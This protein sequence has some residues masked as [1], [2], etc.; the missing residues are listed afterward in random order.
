MMDFGE[1][2]DALKA[3]LCVT[4]KGWNG[5]DMYLYLVD[6]SHFL[7]SRAPLNKLLPEGTKVDY[8][9]HIDMR[10]A[11]GSMV[12]WTASQTDVLACDW[13]IVDPIG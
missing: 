5:K 7:V 9:S 8:R 2:L 4:R 10:T 3:G 6:G 12:P 1:A 11:D 13:D